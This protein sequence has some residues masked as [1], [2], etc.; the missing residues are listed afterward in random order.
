MCIYVCPCVLSRLLDVSRCETTPV[1]QIVLSPLLKVLNHVRVATQQGNG[2][3]S[4]A[5]DE[6]DKS[7]IINTHQRK[8]KKERIWCN[9]TS[10]F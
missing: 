5:D 3:N 9:T 7:I 2:C 1:F 10:Q 6:T 8:G 4:F